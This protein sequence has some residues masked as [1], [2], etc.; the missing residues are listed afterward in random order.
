MRSTGEGPAV[1]ID[2]ACS[3]SLVAVH[4][5]CRALRAGDCEIAVVAA[6]NVILWP[7]SH[8]LAEPG[9]HAFS[10]WPVQDV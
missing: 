7:A 9:A 2:T 8:G 10:G 6:V 1:T 5:A 3:S 4:Q